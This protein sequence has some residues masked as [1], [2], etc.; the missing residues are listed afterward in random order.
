MRNI[1]LGTVLSIFI[2]ACSGSGNAAVVN[3]ENDIHCSVLSFYFHGL[4][5]HNGL[6]DEQLRASKGLEDWYAAKM[7]KALGEH[8]SDPAI[9]KS[10]IEPI[11][12]VVKADPLS[13]RDEVTACAKRASAD[14]AFDMFA[15]SYMRP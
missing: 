15:R 10:E 14:P 1:V 6:S 12:E 7:R 5:K 11:L 3:P 2:C 8:Y 9:M 13:M 4:A